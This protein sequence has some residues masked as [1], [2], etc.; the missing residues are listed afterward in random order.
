MHFDKRI[1]GKQVIC[2]YYH[3]YTS[4]TS[5]EFTHKYIVMFGYPDNYIKML[6]ECLTPIFTY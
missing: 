3:S 1:P 6:L 2:K 4:V 5:S